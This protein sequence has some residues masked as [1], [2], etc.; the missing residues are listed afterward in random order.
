MEKYDQNTYVGR[1][2]HFMEITSPLNCLITK[3]KLEL[4]KQTLKDFQEGKGN[5]SK[6]DYF[7]AK[8]GLEKRKKN[9]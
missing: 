4:S 8:N 2:R 3:K 9:V 1:V 6:D 7:K 5:V